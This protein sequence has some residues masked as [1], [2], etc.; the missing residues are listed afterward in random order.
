MT[1]RIG[2]TVYVPR[3]EDRR[4]ELAHRGRQERARLTRR[5]RRFTWL[6]HLDSALHRSRG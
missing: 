4:G 3:G 1:V 5:T 6:S 2:D